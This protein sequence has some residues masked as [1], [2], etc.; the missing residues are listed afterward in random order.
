LLQ[1]AGTLLSPTVGG[2]GAREA[3]QALLLT[4]FYDSDPSRAVLAASLGFVAAEAATLWGGV[5]LWTRT[6]AWRPTFAT[7][8][9]E[10]VGPQAPAVAD[11]A[12]AASDAAVAADLEGPTA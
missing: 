8:D 9:G 2:E 7:V 10:P 6:A 12:V 5:F 11:A 3:L 4:D 1:I